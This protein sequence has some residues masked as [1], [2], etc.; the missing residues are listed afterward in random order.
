MSKILE[1]SGIRKAKKKLYMALL[2]KGL[3]NLTNR[4][5]NILKHLSLDDD[6]I[7]MLSMEN[8]FSEEEIL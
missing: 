6:I 5:K 3:N 4:E 8:A 1:I 7:L 2:N